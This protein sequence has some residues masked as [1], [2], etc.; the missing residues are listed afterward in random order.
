MRTPLPKFQLFLVMLIQVAEPITGLVIYPFIN[1]FIRDTGVTKG[2]DR[3]VGYYAGIIESAF[4]F[5][6]ALTVFQWGWLS[7]RIGRKP[8]LLLGPLGLMCAMFKFGYST[9]FWPLVWSR[10][11][12]GAFNGNIGVSKTV[13]IELTDETNVGDAV[14]MIPLMWSF[15]STIA[16]F[17]GGILSNPAKRWP[18]SFGKFSLFTDH[19]YFLPCFAAGCIA[20]LAFVVTFLGLK[21]TH[22]TVLARESSRNPKAKQFVYDSEGNVNGSTETLLGQNNPVVYGSTDSTRCPSIVSDYAIIGELDAIPQEPPDPNTPTLLSALKSRTLQLTI[23]NFAFLAFSEMCF[24]ALMPLMYSTSIEYGGLG[25]NPYEIGVIMGIWGFLNVFVQMTVLGSVI[26]RFGASRVY[27]FSYSAFFIVFLTFPFSAYMARRQGGMGA[28]V[29]AS[30]FIQLTFQFFIPMGF[31]SIHVVIAE[32][33]PKPVLGSINGIAQMVGSMM[34]T[35]APTFA[36]SLFSMSLEER[37]PLGR[38]FVYGVILVLVAGGIACSLTLP[39]RMNRLSSA[40]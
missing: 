5:T 9:S 28:G 17:M 16:P 12:Q 7:D 29:Y 32:T 20:L 34:R 22:P 23:V 39:E 37:L 1:Q 30:I 21:E 35:I 40:S 24:S 27:Q 15:G 38:N 19:P 33:T 10:C 2:D 8:V 4:F 6:E 25:L 11:L 26:R 13:V 14:A 36:S 3:K 31:G 18:E